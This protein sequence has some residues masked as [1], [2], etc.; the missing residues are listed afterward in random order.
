MKTRSNFVSFPTEFDLRKYEDCEKFGWAEW[1]SNLMVR[2][3]RLDT[4]RKHVDFYGE[5]MRSGFRHWFEAPLVKSLEIK[6]G[7]GYSKNINRSQVK[8]VTALDYLT[9]Q[10]ILYSD[11]DRHKP[12]LNAVRTIEREWSGDGSNVDPNAVAAALDILD[13]PAWKMVSE[14]GVNLMGEISATVDLYASEEKLI[15]DFRRWLRKTR[16]AL[17]IPDMKKRFSAD[18]FRE[19]HKYRILAYLDLLSWAQLFGHTPTN[20][21]FGI[22]LFP[23]EYTVNLADRM[24][25]TVA[26]TALSLATATT[27]D[28]LFGQALE[29]VERNNQKNIPDQ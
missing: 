25:K 13:T 3:L 4:I 23:D 29:E 8:D 14:C 9:G 6:E 5:E 1:Y 17:G 27:M 19:W 10:S 12:Y 7:D 18:D 24:R 28:A 16:S 11:D 2:T 22:A 21:Q 20:Q 15:D 26:P